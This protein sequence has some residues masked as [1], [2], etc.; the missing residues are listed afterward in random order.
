MR[1]RIGRIFTMGSLAAIGL[2]FLGT[3]AQAQLVRYVASNGDNANNCQRATPCRTLQ[4]GIN[5]TPAGGELQI[6]DSGTYGNTATIGKSITIS[7]DGVSATIGALTIDAPGETVVLRGLMLNGSSFAADTNGIH[8]VAGPFGANNVLVHILRCEIERFPGS[9]GSGGAGI[10][11]DA[12][13]NAYVVI[14]NTIIR[15]NDG[16]G[17]INNSAGAHVLVKSS[18]VA[19][20]G[21]A[22][23]VQA[24][25]SPSQMSIESS[26]VAGNGSGVGAVNGT[27][28][29]S[30]SVITGNSVGLSQAGG[31]TVL[32]RRNNTVSGNNQETNGIITTLDGI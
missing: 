13:T 7:A 24:G 16:P 14:S 1:I 11:I 32:S 10:T 19:N 17:I 4:K 3:A 21:A 28:R 2:V 6:L 18:T 31:S 30:D 22:G 9:P 12:A 20:S 15:D 29:I 26:V 8:I 27:L 5:K 23:I 25:A